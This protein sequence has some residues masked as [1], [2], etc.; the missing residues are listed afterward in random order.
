MHT[1]LSFAVLALLHAAELRT[2]KF[3]HFGNVTIALKQSAK[4]KT[5]TCDIV[6]TIDGAHASLKHVS[7]LSPPPPDFT[8]CFELPAEQVTKGY[9]MVRENLAT[10]RTLLISEQGK[11]I[12]AEQTR[13]Q[14]WEAVL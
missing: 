12:D 9:F 10:P 1:F 3:I 11:V 6:T 5:V 13:V 8:S 4:D 2:E 14:Q 7:Q